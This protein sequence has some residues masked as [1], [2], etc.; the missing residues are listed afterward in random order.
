[1]LPVVTAGLTHG[2]ALVSMLFVD[3][4]TPV[5]MPNPCWGN[6][7][8]IFGRVQGADLRA[9]RL[10][11]AQRGPQGWLD[12]DALA[13]ALGRLSRPSLLVLNFP[14]NPLG[15]SPTPA[16][17]DRLIDCISNTPVPLVVV[18]DDAYQGMSWEPEIYPHSL[19][20]RLAAL[21]ADRVLA[22]KIDGATKELFYFGG[23]V[24]FLTCGAAGSAA[25]VLE[26]K[27][28]AAARASISSASATAQAVL[29]QALRDPDLPAQQNQV[30]GR[31]R[32]RYRILKRC[33]QDAGLVA[34]PFNSGMFAVID[35]PGD[36]ET[37]RQ[38]LLA[39]GIGVVSLSEI[40]ALR[41]SYGS[42]ASADIPPLVQSI[43]RHLRGVL[44]EST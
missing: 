16:E 27:T 26:E 24:G 32:D 14:S 21:P 38:A 6:Y 19:F 17:V 15:Y 8:A 4:G 31:L 13:T 3:P 7:A 42:L 35:V 11:R 23:R 18:C 29:A 12:I 25:L 10:L 39:D 40:G 43:A 44:V 36:P 30:R 20:H 33:M 41:L 22:V 37:L 5:L 34:R 2:I 1:M 28:R 9:W